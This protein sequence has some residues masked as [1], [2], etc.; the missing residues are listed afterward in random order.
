MKALRCGRRVRCGV[1]EERFCCSWIG[2]GILDSKILFENILKYPISLLHF[3]H[4]WLFDP[5]LERCQASPTVPRVGIIKGTPITQKF[6]A[7]FNLNFSPDNSIFTESGLSKGLFYT[8]IY[9]FGKSVLPAFPQ[10]F[11][12]PLAWWCFRF[13]AG[14]SGVQLFS[15]P[16]AA[17]RKLRKRL[18]TLCD[19]RPPRCSIAPLC[20]VA[21]VK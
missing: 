1:W 9:H 8:F 20:Q 16:W 13:S 6:L 5:Q 15:G 10:F 19:V 11:Y 3:V 12:Q 17:L 4:P 18:P 2:F 21:Y 14:R 7:N